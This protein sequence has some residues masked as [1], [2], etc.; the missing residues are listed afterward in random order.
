MIMIGRQS[1]LEKKKELASKLAGV[2]RERPG[3]NP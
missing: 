1:D 3:A 2:S